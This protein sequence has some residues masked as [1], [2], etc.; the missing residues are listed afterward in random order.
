MEKQNWQPSVDQIMVKR[1][2]TM[3]YSSNAFTWYVLKFLG[4]FLGTSAQNGS[5]LRREF[6]GGSYGAKRQPMA[7]PSDGSL[8]SGGLD[9]GSD[10]PVREYEREVSI[11]SSLCSK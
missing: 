10:A 9:Q 1:M 4:A 8:S 2:N 11:S 3:G 7:S 6:S 5:A